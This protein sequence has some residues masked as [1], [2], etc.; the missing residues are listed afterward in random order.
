MFCRKRIYIHVTVE[1]EF[2]NALR[3][4]LRESGKP[5]IAQILNTLLYGCLRVAP[6]WFV[7]MHL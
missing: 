4:I 5:S 1:D 7:R 6:D 2:L 3:R